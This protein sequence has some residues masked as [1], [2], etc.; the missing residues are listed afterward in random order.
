MA[1]SN[2]KKILI[3]IKYDK[4]KTV[5]SCSCIRRI[6]NKSNL[7]QGKEG[8]Q[9][10]ILQYTSHCDSWPLDSNPESGGR[11]F[12]SVVGWSHLVIVSQ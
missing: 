4:D 9:K 2:H 10:T 7:Q 5:A 11:G 1:L 6:V 12:N 8:S 3:L